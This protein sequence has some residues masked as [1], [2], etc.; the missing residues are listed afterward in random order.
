MVNNRRDDKNGLWTISQVEKAAGRAPEN[1]RRQA[2]P[3]AR[4][5]TN[6][7]RDNW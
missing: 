6:Q 5:N 4:I 7:I 3:I 2:T 1:W